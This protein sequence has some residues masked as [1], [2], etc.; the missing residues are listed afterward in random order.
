MPTLVVD[1]APEW[2]GGDSTTS[3]APLA[4]AERF[5]RIR[6]LVVVAVALC[7]LSNAVESFVDDAFRDDDEVEEA[8]VPTWDPCVLSSRLWLLPLPCRSS[9][10]SDVVGFVADCRTPGGSIDAGSGRL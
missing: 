1:T 6:F 2:G 7:R 3:A 4:A 9:I 10:I 5:R 8:L